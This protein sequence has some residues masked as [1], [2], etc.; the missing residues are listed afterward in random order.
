MR[1]LKDFPKRNKAAFIVAFA[2]LLL[3]A[4]I[5]CYKTTH[6]LKWAAEP[7]FDR[8]IS[9]IQGTLDG[10]LGKDPSYAGAYL[11]YNPLLFSI[12]T[13]IVEVSGLPIH[14]V[15]TRAG[16]YLNLL[17]PIAFIIMLVVLVNYR[18]ALAAL[19]SYL[20]L[21]SGNIPGWGAATYS[22]WLYPV[23][24]TQFLFYLSIIFFYK[25]FSKQ[26]Y[27]WFFIAGA[28]TGICF[29]G[30]AAP[31]ILIV[32]MM[33]SIQG[34]NIIQ[35][36]KEKDY[37][38]LKKYMWQGAATFVPFILTSFPLLFFVV[39]KYHLHFI[40]RM[41]S[42]F[43]MGIF[44]RQN[45]L[46]M[47][48][49]NISG[50]FIISIVGFIWFYKKFHQPLV[51]KIILNWFFI[52]ILMYAY[53]S[54]V[55]GL[56]RTLGIYLP[57]TVP[58]F[59]Y[60][61]YFKALQSVFFGFGFVFLIETLVRLSGILSKIKLATEGNN[62]NRFLIIAVVLCAIIYFPFYKNRADFVYPREQA[63]IKQ[64]DKDK[65]EVYN[66]IVQ[67]LSPDEVILCDLQNSL[68]PVMPTARKLVAIHPTFSNPY[69]DFSNRNAA[70]D[71]MLLFLKTG[72]P[73]GARKLFDDYRVDFVLLP[74]KGLENFKNV[75]SLLEHVVFKNNG[76]TM[77]AVNDHRFF[78]SGIKR[79]PSQE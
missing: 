13:A 68:F 78:S 26:S 11:W 24:F 12:E 23:C 57:V 6:D 51:R 69:H 53:S 75:S 30:H 73:Q 19:L 1:G 79:G 10:K 20:F 77:F 16:T 27:F 29:L 32:L 58:S 62:K 50:S 47:I 44:M 18:V 37:P 65:I 15:V 61:F 31:A 49:A 5:Q 54:V 28:T 8:D 9:Y 4:F 59:H 33:T 2:M 67:N 35:A 46:E 56:E 7:D 3:M 63:I 34:G 14:T 70:R 42:Q 74:N 71:N 21:A 22:P 45:F 39:G 40:N 17:S 55:P 52:S 64:N 72:A 60:F 25:A 76:Y 48:T 43:V 36:V 38:T 41:I 66:Y